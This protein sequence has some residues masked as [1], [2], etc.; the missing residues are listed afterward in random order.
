MS[1]CVAGVTFW[2]FVT[3]P[4]CLI[5]CRKS[6]CVDGAILLRRF[7]Q[8]SWQAQHFGDLYRHFAWQ[9]QHFRRVALRALHFT[10]RTLHSTLHPLHFTLY[11]S[12]STLYT[13]HSTLYTLHSTL[14]TSHSTLHTP[15][16]TLHTSHSTL[17]TLHSTLYTSHSTLY[18]LHSTL[19]TLHSS[20]YIVTFVSAHRDIRVCTS[21]RESL[22]VTGA[23]LVR[24][25]QTRPACVVAGAS[26][27]TWSF[28]LF[29]WQ[30]HH[31]RQVVLRVFAES[32]FGIRTIIIR[33]SIRV[34]GMHL[35]S[36]ILGAFGAANPC[37]SVIIGVQ[38]NLV[39]HLWWLIIK[40]GLSTFYHDE[41]LIMYAA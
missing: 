5:T 32:R 38:Y 30:A 19:N 33:V 16:F 34:R 7:L 25:V 18:T 4:T 28:S 37:W 17:Y 2:P 22:R 10:L 21:C 12:H 11:T 15:H 39:Y 6:F 35:V 29:A 27:W 13:L 24:G 8:F 9:A 36:A 14:Y 41:S 20:L 1:F 3:L 31:F 40:T 23:I 26:F